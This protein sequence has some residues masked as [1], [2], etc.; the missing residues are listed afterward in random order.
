MKVKIKKLEDRAIIPEYKSEGAAGFDFHAIDS[1]TVP[2]GRSMKVRTGI[3]MEIP[4]GYEVQVRPRSGL[5]ANTSL[6]VSN[7]PGTLDSDFRGEIMILIDNIDQNGA[8]SVRIDA[9]ERIAQ[10]VLQKV[11]QIEFVEVE[12][13]TETERGEGGFGSTGE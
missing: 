2:A 10:G 1:I 4:A 3:A 5:S 8:S 13:L 11:E 12:E 9:G 6:R 7:S